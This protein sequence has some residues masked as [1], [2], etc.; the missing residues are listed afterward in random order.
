MDGTKL[1]ESQQLEGR[2]SGS[3]VVSS[4]GNW[5]YLT[6]NSERNTVGHFTILTPQDDALQVVVSRN[7]ETLPFAPPGIFH[8]PVEGFFE[9]PV[10]GT[11]NTNDI[12]LW[13]AAPVESGSTVEDGF[14][15]GFQLA[16]DYAG[17]TADLDYM[18][19][20]DSRS[21]RTITAPLITNG[22]R[23]A[24]WPA[25]RSSYFG[26]LGQANLK[27][28]YFNRKPN[29]KVEYTLNDDWRG[30]PCFALPAESVGDDGN[31]TIFFGTA[32]E[33][34]VRLHYYYNDNK[35]IE[36][37]NI[38][39][40]TESFILAAPIVDPYKRAVY[41]VESVGKIH[42]VDHEDI[43]EM[44]S[45]P[46]EIQSGVQGEMA[47]NGDG[48]ML[49]AGSTS[50]D[51]MAIQVAGTTLPPTT[52]APT[53]LASD[54]PSAVPTTSPMPTTTRMP[55]DP[56]VTNCDGDEDGDCDEDSA[57]F[58]IRAA[59]PLMFMFVLMVASLCF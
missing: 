10:D 25:S 12:V 40:V 2:Q 15:F 59:K 24:Y 45:S 30:Q 49:Y 20:G 42:Q 3:P 58:G 53:P 1:Y 57:P 35:N 7:N 36:Y 46:L 48:S 5:I 43:S 52:A 28:A 22:G 44:W 33:E 17:E 32:S 50:G 4:D 41:F 13:S 47:L 16:L 6:H 19:L 37:Q 34:F 27:R 31:T 39:A 54:A 51:V 29:L 38:S 9:S 55:T 26:F 8:N 14:T 23:S 56:P 11:G 21:F 18:V